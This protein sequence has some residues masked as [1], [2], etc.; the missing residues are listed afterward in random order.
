MLWFS[1]TKIVITNVD[2]IQENN[3]FGSVG[4]NNITHLDTNQLIFRGMVFSALTLLKI[5]FLK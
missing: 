3:V 1:I 4:I 2:H 5:I